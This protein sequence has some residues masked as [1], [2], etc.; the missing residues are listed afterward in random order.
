MTE[1][2]RI[3]YQMVRGVL[4]APPCINGIVPVICD[5]TVHSRDQKTEAIPGVGGIRTIGH[6]GCPGQHRDMATEGNPLKH[7]GRAE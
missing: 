6:I 4:T 7:L 3:S 2:L 5:N 1:H